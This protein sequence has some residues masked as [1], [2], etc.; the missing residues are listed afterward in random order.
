MRQQTDQTPRT[1]RYTPNNARREVRKL[2]TK[3]M[4]ESWRREYRRLKKSRPGMT[5]V[6]YSHRIAKMAI[7]ELRSA[8]TIRKHMTK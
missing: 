4:H 2:N 5:D 7:A 8:E 1:D 6:W 3:A